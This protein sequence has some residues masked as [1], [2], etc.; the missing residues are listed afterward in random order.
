MFV[1]SNRQPSGK[2]QPVPCTRLRIVEYLGRP[3]RRH[4]V[5]LHFS[6]SF[7]PP[8]QSKTPFFITLDES[9]L[10]PGSTLRLPPATK[11]PRAVQL[12]Q[13]AVLEHGLVIG[14]RFHRP[15]TDPQHPLGR[16]TL[17][18]DVEVNAGLAL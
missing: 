16:V 15:V 1:K 8:P 13:R 14:F 5:S 2:L 4:T 3:K 9:E 18:K 7:Q 11:G 17:Q 6:F 10:H 12:D